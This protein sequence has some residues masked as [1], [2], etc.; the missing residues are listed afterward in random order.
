MPAV[1]VQWKDQCILL[2]CGEGTQLQLRQARIRHNRIQLIC[3]THL[4][5]DHFLGLP[6]LLITMNLT[7]RRN[8]LTVVAPTELEHALEVL[9]GLYWSEMRFPIHFIGL[10]V[11]NAAQPVYQNRNLTVI[12]RPLDHRVFAVGYRVQVQSRTGRLDVDAAR[13]LGVTRPEQFGALKQGAT[14]TTD[15]GA[16]VAPERVLSDPKPE[17]SFAYVTDTRP[18]Q[19]GTDL[20]AHATLLWHDATFAHVLRHRAIETGHTTALEAGQVANAS[21]AKRL[22]LAH[23]SARYRDLTELELEAR[24]VFANAHAAQ[25][26]ERYVLSSDS[27]S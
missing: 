26:L 18:C 12:A 7:G 16:K 4:H 5:G 25:E 3:I 8:P 15:S 11:S 1:V 17:R 21:G 27:L 19:G 24:E 23:F 2:D 20:A 14:V 9:P 6:G 10:D 13:A 22:L